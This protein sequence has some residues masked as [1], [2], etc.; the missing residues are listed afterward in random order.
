MFKEKIAARIIQ[1]V[2]KNKS[3]SAFKLSP[4]ELPDYPEPDV[5]KKYLLYLH[6]PFCKTFCSYC[7]F[8][9]VS[10]KPKQVKAYF[11]ALREDIKRAAAKGYHFQGVYIGGGTPTLAPDEALDAVTPSGRPVR[12]SA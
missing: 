8:Y 6:I 4:V 1:T 9:K 10:Y 5:D 7:S 12:S 3:N 2:V 11:K